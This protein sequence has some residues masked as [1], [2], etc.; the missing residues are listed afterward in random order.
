ME[1]VEPPL[2]EVRPLEP[3]EL[4]LELSELLDDESLEELVELSV[5]LEELSVVDDELSL[6]E[7][8]SLVLLD[9]VE[10]AV[11]CASDCIVPTRAKTPAAAAR[12]RAAAKAVVRRAPLR[13]A[14]T[15]PLSSSLLGM[16]APLRS[17]VL[18]RT[19]FGERSERSL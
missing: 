11:V 7:V 8:E 9:V 1:S 10:L 3:L 2:E 6:P 5:V 4:E 16:T 19:T 12:V 17:V 15:A 13:T 14:A 18:S